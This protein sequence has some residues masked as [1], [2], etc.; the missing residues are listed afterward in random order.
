MKMRSVSHAMLGLLFVG[1]SAV[2]G[3][4]PP[5]RPPN[6]EPGPVVEI[7][8]PMALSAVSVLMKLH[9]YGNADYATFVNAG[10][11]VTRMAYQAV[12]PDVTTYE[13]RIE[14]CNTRSGLCLGGAELRVTVSPG[15]PSSGGAEVFTTAVSLL[16]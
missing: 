8:D 12:K 14:N 9:N 13:F 3:A 4:M 7:A 11:N 1:F 6:I 5:V 10:N 15:T 16:R 2:A